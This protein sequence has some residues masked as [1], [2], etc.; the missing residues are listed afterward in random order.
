MHVTLVAALLVAGNVAFD[1]GGLSSASVSNPAYRLEGLATKAVKTTLT[2]LFL[3]A[4]KRTRTLTPSAQVYLDTVVYGTG[5]GNTT[6]PGPLFRNPIIVGGPG[7][8]F[9]AYAEFVPVAHSALHDQVALQDGGNVAIFEASPRWH[10]LQIGLG[11]PTCVKAKLSKLAP[12]PVVALW[13][14]HSCQ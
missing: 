1:G 9:W 10:V 6:H 3:S 7:H 14:A 4:E 11:W 12:A 5:P 8:K 2:K 13:W